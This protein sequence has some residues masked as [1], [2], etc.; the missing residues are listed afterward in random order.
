MKRSKIYVL[1]LLCG[2]AGLWP[3][4]AQEPNRAGRMSLEECIEYAQKHSPQLLSLQPQVDALQLEHR[5]AKDA[6]LPGI[7][8]TVG[9]DFSFAH[10]KEQGVEAHRVNSANTSF[11]IAGDITIWSG[12]TWYQLKKSQQAL[13]AKA[14]IEADLMDNIALQVT[15]SYIQ[16]LLAEQ[17]AITAQENLALTEHNYNQVKEQVRVGKMAP[18]QQIEIESQMGRDQLAVVETQ[19][20]VARAKKALL[21]DM[22]AD[23][24]TDINV[25]G[26]SPETVVNRLEKANPL[27]IN[28]DW[29]LPR[30]ALMQH[31]LTLATYDAK[32]AESRY[33]PSLAINAGYSNGYTY[34][35]GERY[36]NINL[37]FA[38][39]IKQN[40]RTFVGLTLSIPIFNRGQ[41]STQ[42]RQARI[43]QM[44]LQSQLIQRK[45]EDKRNIVLAETDLQKAEEQYRV[46]KAN[47][48]LAQKALDVAD[49]EYRAGRI[50]TYE[51]EQ[52]KNRRL[53]AQATYLQSIYT[54]LLRTINL[55]YFHTGEIPVELTR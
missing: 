28:Y 26:I 22:G 19:A 10:S 24:N 49:T 1:L 20:D 2:F 15:A 6:F 5:A 48:E 32:I 35:F 42:I 25:D 8:A 18:S 33:Y 31:D 52:A 50:G 36:K 9:E 41:V 4:K 46:S 53:Q 23:L 14:Y 11:Q 39:Q 40:G 38:D 29:V 37:S 55:T 12:A 43:Q 27:A 13:E 7:N 44:R 47:V 16:L 34:L 21:L 17:M 51:W 3:M 54:R 30:T 45:H